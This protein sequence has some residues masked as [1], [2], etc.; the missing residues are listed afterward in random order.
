MGVKLYMFNTEIQICC[1]CIILIYLK[2][3]EIVW[4]RVYILYYQFLFCIIHVWGE[5]YMFV[6]GLNPLLMAKQS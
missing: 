3:L 4:F 1:N 6:S 2:I 5:K